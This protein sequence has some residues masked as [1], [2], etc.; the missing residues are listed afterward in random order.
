[1]AHPEARI[2]ALLLVAV[3]LL[4]AGSVV[5]SEVLH[6][7][8]G[9]MPR[10][11]VRTQ[12]LKELWR[13]GNEAD[14][15]FFGRVPRVDTD[16]QGNV[17]VLDSQLCQVHVY[18]PAGEHLRTL[19]R[20]GDGPGEARGPRDMLL[21]PDG[22]VG[23]MLE[24]LGIVTFVDA[25]GDPAGSLRLG[26]SD[27]GN[28]ALVA[29]RGVDGA[30]VLAGRCSTPGETRAIRNRRNFLVRSDLNG[31]ENA[32]YAESHW[33][34]DFNDLS[35]VELDELPSFNWAFDVGAD[36]RVFAAVARERY[37]V[38]VY[39][40]DGTPS[41]V[42]DREYSLL[43]RTDEDRDRFT[44]LIESSMEGMPFTTKVEMEDTYPA[45]SVL[46]RGVQVTADGSLWVLSGRGMK[47]DA[48][49]IMAIYDVFDREGVFVR[50]VALAA[51]H[52]ASRSGIVLA[53]GNRVI[54]VEGFMES[55]AFQFGNGATF[56]GEEWNTPEVIVYEMRASN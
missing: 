16:R 17:Y 51:P 55:L 12:V 48:P 7:H 52:D 18:S 14:G 45:I 23:L 9:A 36:G 19:F 39:A 35:Y 1:M 2:Y 29:G 44:H 40:S 53:G 31:R 50:Q 37:E 43:S 56:S 4:S 26:G 42:I 24:S 20:E 41:M 5:G 33:V 15:V 22:G 6:V 21:M 32:V 49:G 13:V 11:G 46:Q 54:V 38:T 47:P 30:V 27:G 3:L 25:A 8:N 10:D 28:Y 34:F